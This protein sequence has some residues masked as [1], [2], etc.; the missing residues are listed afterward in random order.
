VQHDLIETQPLGLLVSAGSAGLVANHLPFLLYRTEGPLG[1][2]RCHLSKANE[3]WRELFASDDCLVAF[4][5]PQ[6][7]I[8]P[9]WYPSKRESGKVV[10]TWNYATVH[11]WGRPEVKEDP[12]WLHRHVSDLTDT[13]EG[14]LPAPWRVDDA[15]EPFVASQLKGIV[16]VQIAITRLEG[17]WKMSQNRSV[18]DRAGVAEA[19]R[20]PGNGHNEVADL[21]ERLGAGTDA[22]G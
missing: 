13:N 17:K 4:Q 5:G 15:P 18:P 16:G 7:Y 9:N 2:L 14:R 20:R 10:P 8:S 11:A 21:V 6:A 3:Q 19:L 12:G 1:T 22:E